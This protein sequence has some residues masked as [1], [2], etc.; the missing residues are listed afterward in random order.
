MAPLSDPINPTIWGDTRGTVQCCHPERESEE[1][2]RRNVQ[3]D[4]DYPWDYQ[5]KKGG[6]QKDKDHQDHQG[7]GRGEGLGSGVSLEILRI[8]EANA[9]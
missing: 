4:K 6:M 3:K 5:E 1:K 9:K 2:G 7:G 8:L